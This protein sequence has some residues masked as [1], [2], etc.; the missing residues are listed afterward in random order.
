[1]S[2]TESV[3][4]TPS[5]RPP[6]WYDDPDA[7]DLLR[8]WDGSEWSDQEF[9]PRPEDSELVTYVKSYRD[10]GPRSPTNFLAIS[11]LV[12]ASMALILA[13]VLVAVSASLPSGTA[14]LGVATLLVLAEVVVLLIGLWSGALGVMAI[15][16]ARRHDGKRIQQANA[17]VL[18]SIAAVMLSVVLLVQ[19]TP[20]WLDSS[21]VIG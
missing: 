21:G 6:G 18:I 8:W 2:R 1:M 9:R 10:L 20:E 15:R 13:A 11:S 4:E 17:A 7:P 3:G 12:Q 19:Q 5:E 16:N 14:T